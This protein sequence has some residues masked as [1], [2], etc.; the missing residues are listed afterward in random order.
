MDGRVGEKQRVIGERERREGRVGEKQRV[1]GEGEGGG[2][3]GGG[4]GGYN[5]R[6]KDYLSSLSKNS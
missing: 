3:E 4:E 6:D 1:I 2:G 5:W